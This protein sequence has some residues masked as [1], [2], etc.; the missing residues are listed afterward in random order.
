MEVSRSRSNWPR[1]PGGGLDE[2]SVGVFKIGPAQTLR[3]D[4]YRTPAFWENDGGRRYR[5]QVE[6]SSRRLLFLMVSKS[7]LYSENRQIYQFSS[8]T[9][10]K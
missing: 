10:R 8:L 6:F 3:V 4:E 5:P 1:A 9:T 7:L 2:G